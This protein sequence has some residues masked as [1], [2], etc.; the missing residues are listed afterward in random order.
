MFFYVPQTVRTMVGGGLP[1]SFLHD[2]REVS[3]LFL[4][5]Q[6]VR[7]SD[8]SCLEALQNVALIAQVL[9]SVYACV[10]IRDLFVGLCLQQVL[11]PCYF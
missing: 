11:F 6:N 3:V 7:A 5:L 8:P 2:I 1:Q 10:C 4:N 9:E